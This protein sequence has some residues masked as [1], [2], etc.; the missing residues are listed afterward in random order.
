MSKTART[1]DPKSSTSSSLEA[2]A[3]ECTAFQT[4]AVQNNDELDF[5]PVAVWEMRA[6]LEAAFQAGRASK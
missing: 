5:Q 1:S 2:I 3:R 6:A 4:L